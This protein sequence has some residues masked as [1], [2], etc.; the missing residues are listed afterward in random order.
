MAAGRGMRR[1]AI[2]IV[3]VAALLIPALIYSSKHTEESRCMKENEARVCFE[4]AARLSDIDVPNDSARAIQYARHGCSIDHLGSC[5]QLYAL[6]LRAKQDQE[7]FSLSTKA[8]AGGD[9]VGCCVYGHLFNKGFRSAPEA[10]ELVTN[11]FRKFS[12]NG[13]VAYREVANG[14]ARRITIGSFAL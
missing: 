10:A 11:Q 5:A 9:E 2:K 8:C 4:V 3:A 1:E 12:C 7:A 6:L 14:R 13:V